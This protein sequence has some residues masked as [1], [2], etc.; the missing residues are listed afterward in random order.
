[1]PWN[2]RFFLAAK[3]FRPDGTAF[4]LSDGICVWFCK[5]IR[6]RCEALNKTKGESATIV[7][8]QIAQCHLC[9]ILHCKGIHACE[10]ILAERKISTCKCEPAFH[11]I[12][13][14]PA[15][16]LVLPWLQ[17][18]PKM[19]GQTQV[20]LCYELWDLSEFN[21]FKSHQTKETSLHHGSCR[22]VARKPRGFRPLVLSC[23]KQVFPVS[24]LCSASP[25]R[26]W[27]TALNSN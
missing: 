7:L 3:N 22:R 19:H 5:W 14:F 2:C 12:L 25:T 11:L 27:N 26:Q 8:C 18:V 16:T 21:N 1:M 6:I 23:W 10:K 15:I 17:K 24:R 20:Y 4:L 9:V 13:S